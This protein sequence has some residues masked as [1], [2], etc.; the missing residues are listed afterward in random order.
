M[1]ELSGLSNCCSRRLAQPPSFSTQRLVV[2]A[3]CVV[4]ENLWP[5]VPMARCAQALRVILTGSYGMA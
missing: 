2:L 1:Y 4:L 3:G 5:L